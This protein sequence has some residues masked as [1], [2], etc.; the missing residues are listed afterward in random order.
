MTNMPVSLPFAHLNLRRNPFGELEPAEQAELAVVDVQRHVER[1]RRPGYAVQF[2]GDRGRGKTTHLLAIRRHFPD[3]PYVH[4]G[5]G[6][7]PRIP[8]G[9]PLFVD[10]IQRFSPWRRR[11][12]F[13]RPV[14][15]ALGTHEDLQAELAASGFDVETVWAGAMLDADRLCQM[16]A[17]RIESARRAPGPLPQLSF[18]TARAMID[19]FDDNLRGIHA[20]LY[21]WFQNLRGIEDV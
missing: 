11:R 5:E 9:H 7:R 17:R 12:L 20:C 19:R 4:I 10:E 18:V 6:Q 15:L 14:S 3:A 1:L 16:A 2:L 21:D 13:R 8:K